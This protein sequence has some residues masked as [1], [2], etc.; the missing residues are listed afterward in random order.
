MY[1]GEKNK[2]EV[3]LRVSGFNDKFMLLVKL[4][5]DE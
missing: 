5:S 2:E 3:P 1:M 4:Y